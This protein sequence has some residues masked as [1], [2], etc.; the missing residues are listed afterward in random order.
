[1]NYAGKKFETFEM[2]FSW[3]A[4][5]RYINNKLGLILMKYFFFFK[6]FRSIFGLDV[7]ESKGEEE[8]N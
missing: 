1:M 4:Y 7:R 3:N 5:L 8:R 2:N 6:S